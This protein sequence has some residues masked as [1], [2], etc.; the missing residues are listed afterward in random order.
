MYTDLQYN[1]LLCK[2]S[3]MKGYIKSLENEYNA[4]K[5]LLK[6]KN[7]LIYDLKNQL[8]LTKNLNE[9]YKKDIERYEILV[10]KICQE[11]NV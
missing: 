8:E 5:Q 1:D 7:L 9:S 6:D 2:N 10:Q 4:I 3:I 11:F